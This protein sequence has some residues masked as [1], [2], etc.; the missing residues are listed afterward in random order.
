MMAMAYVVH[1]RNPLLSWPTLQQ[2]VPSNPAVT[3]SLPYTI[4]GARE[5]LAKVKPFVKA[6]ELDSGIAARVAIEELVYE[7]RNP[8][9]KYTGSEVMNLNSSSLRRAIM[10]RMC[11]DINHKYMNGIN[12]I[13]LNYYRH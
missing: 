12:C 1:R 4:E 7:I 10:A 9:Y 2:T 3:F 13:Y 11:N 5:F 6:C 8:I